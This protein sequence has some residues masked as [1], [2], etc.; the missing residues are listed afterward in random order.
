VNGV[1][2][3]PVRVLRVCCGAVRGAS[4]RTGCAGRRAT[5]GTRTGGTGATAFA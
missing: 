4:H 3:N 2:L 1:A 5:S